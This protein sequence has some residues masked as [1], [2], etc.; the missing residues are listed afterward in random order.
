MTSLFPD[1]EDSAIFSPCGLFRYRLDRVLGSGPAINF[2]LLNP[3]TATAT[4]NDPTIVRCIRRA[5]SLG[6]GRLIVTN[7][8]AWRSTNPH[9]LY[10]LGDMVGIDNNMAILGGAQDSEIVVLGWGNHG[11]LQCRG[12][13]VRSLLRDYAGK[14]RILGTLTGQ[15]QPRHP[16]YVGYDV[17]LNRLEGIAT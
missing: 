5:Q 16:L 13:F 1:M 6:F 17:P 2:L 15:G 9:G 8:F 11:R 12:D 7:I 14:L 3:S 10:K 4:R